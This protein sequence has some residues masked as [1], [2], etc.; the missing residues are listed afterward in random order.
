M[1]VKRFSLTLNIIPDEVRIEPQ[2]SCLFL[3][4]NATQDFSSDV[5]HQIHSKREQLVLSTTH[6]H[7]H[8]YIIIFLT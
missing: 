3:K 1:Y 6:T 7:T 2:K 5:Y 4:H 8:I